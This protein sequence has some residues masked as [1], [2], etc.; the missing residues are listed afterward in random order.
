MPHA[1]LTIGISASGKT[2]WAYKEGK[3]IVISRDNYRWMIMEEKNIEPSWDNW[4]WKWEDEVT[5]RVNADVDAHIARGDDLIIAD[6]NLSAKTRAA[7]SEKFHAA[8]YTVEMRFFDI[9]WDEAVK[10]DN[11]REN[12][13]GYSVLQKQHQQFL[14]Q[15]GERVK[16]ADWAPSAVIVDIDGTVALMNGKRGPFEWHKVDLDDKHQPIIEMVK[17]LRAAGH[18]VLFTSGRSDECRQLTLKWLGE[19]FPEFV[20][21]RDFTLL[22]R[23]AADQRKDTIVKREIFDEFIL[24]FYKI[25]VVL[26]DR[27]SVCR[28]WRDLGLNVVQVGNPYIEF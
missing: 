14:D 4:K 8:G 18:Y 22:M 7:W 27:P 9:E 26:D 20:E 28:M 17:G 3:G 13:V 12:G 24:S 15:F 19:A 16:F 25:V 10:R 5:R 21:F 1:V 6:T 11:R 23:K 2:T